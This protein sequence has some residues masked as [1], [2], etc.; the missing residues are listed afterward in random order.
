MTIPLW[1]GALLVYVYLMIMT[2]IIFF[3]D[4][5]IGDL[6]GLSFGDSFYFAFVSLRSQLGA[7]RV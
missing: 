5:E 3:L 2:S 7:G 6:D 4:Y 1:I